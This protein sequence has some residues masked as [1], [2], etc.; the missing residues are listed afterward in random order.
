M[1][2][3]GRRTGAWTKKQFV[4]ELNPALHSE[5][6]VNLHKEMIVQ[7][8]L[9]Q[10][11]EADFLVTII[12]KLHMEV[13]MPGDL[14]ICKGSK[15]DEMY[16]I[17][18]GRCEVLDAT[19]DTKVVHVFQPGSYFGEV[20]V[21]SDVRRTAT[22][23]AQ[24]YCDL[25]V[26]YKDDFL[27]TLNDYPVSAMRVR[28][29]MDQRMEELEILGVPGK[30]AQLKNVFSTFDR[31]GEG[32]IDRNEIADAFASLGAPLTEVQANALMLK[33][34]TDHSG[35][36]NFQEFRQ[37]FVQHGLVNMSDV[38]LQWKRDAMAHSAKHGL[39]ATEE[40]LKDSF[41]LGFH[42]NLEKAKVESSDA[43]IDDKLLTNILEDFNSKINL[44]FMKMQ[45]KFDQTIVPL[46]ESIQH[47]EQRCDKQFEALSSDLP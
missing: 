20:A 15:G 45:A 41:T 14:I 34:D 22:V 19:D 43:K 9:F 28:S 31:D 26:L 32:E 24:S 2:T 42:T 3:C 30:E 33:V 7:V 12:K 35:S 18:R 1:I 44:R 13:A 4:E 16:F 5:I 10:E 27:K 40:N 11:C 23:R 38:A 8:P 36:I 29:A 17:G 6:T 46:V 47:M 39:G 21:L 37:V 25:H